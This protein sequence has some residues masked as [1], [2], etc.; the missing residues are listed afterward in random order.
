MALKYLALITQ[1][2]YELGLLAR[3][4]DESSLLSPWMW[5]LS[6]LVQLSTRALT[7]TSVQKQIITT[8][9]IWQEEL[10][11]LCVLPAELAA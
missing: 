9:N 11:D 10:P 3:M 7:T 5:L 8:P 1:L 4:T 6:P 2:S